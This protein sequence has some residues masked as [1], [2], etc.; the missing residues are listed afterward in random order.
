MTRDYTSRNLRTGA[1]IATIQGMSENELNPTSE[2]DQPSAPTTPD[3]DLSA[4][5]DTLVMPEKVVEASDIPAEEPVAEAEA[6]IEPAPL[7]EALD[8]PDAES[9]AEPASEPEPETEVVVETQTVSEDW[10]PGSSDIDAALAAVASLSEIMPEREAEAEARAD[11]RQSAPTFVPEMP[12][13]PLTTLKRGQLGSLV[14]ALLLIALGAWLTITTTSGTPPNPLLVSAAVVGGLI[15]TLL[16]EWLGTGRWSRG[17]L[18]FALIVL[19]FTGVIAFSIQPQGIDLQRGYPLLIVAI[20]L[21]L[22]LAGFLSRPVN[23][24]LIAPGALVILAGVV[25][26]VITLGLIPSDLLT[27]AVPAAPVVLVIVLVLWLLP[28]IFRRRQ[29]KIER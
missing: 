24:R 19:F 9:E 21:A 15:L 27:W 17:I 22:L 28:L 1:K 14:P 18:F 26:M 2:S 13:P 3:A 12:M 8:Q 25:G 20:G 11:A 29:P 4:S 5:D 16:A 10:L 23:A 6:E 7:I